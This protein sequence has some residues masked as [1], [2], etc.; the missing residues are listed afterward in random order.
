LHLFRLQGLE[1]ARLRM[2][3]A[4]KAATAQAPKKKVAI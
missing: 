4:V 3:R 2:R 1:A